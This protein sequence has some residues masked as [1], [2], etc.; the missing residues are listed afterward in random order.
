MYA[1]I[2]KKGSTDIEFAWLCDKAEMTDGA[3]VC[4]Y[5]GEVN[6]FEDM[7][8]VTHELTNFEGS[9]PEGF[10]AAEYMLVD[11]NIIKK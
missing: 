7:T 2:T 5:A 4:Q 8:S 9:L 6:T 11:G 10:V 3:L 1:I